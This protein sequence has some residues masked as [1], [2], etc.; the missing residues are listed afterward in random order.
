MGNLS[1]TRY[2]FG[3]EAGEAKGMECL[4]FSRAKDLAQNCCWE[5][6]Q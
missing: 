4:T 2:L 6:D 1:E 3:H 5:E